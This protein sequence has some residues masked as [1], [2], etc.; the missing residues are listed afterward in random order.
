[1]RAIFWLVCNIAASGPLLLVVDDAHWV[2]A[3]S[4]RSQPSAPVV[5]V[6]KAVVEPSSVN[7]IRPSGPRVM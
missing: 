1:M 5:T 4:L 3:S 7:H 2:D 6:P